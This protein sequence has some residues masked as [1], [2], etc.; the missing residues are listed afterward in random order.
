V[1]AIPSQT[2]VA[3]LEDKTKNRTVAPQQT[4]TLLK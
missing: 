4:L 1:Y 3:H 2:L